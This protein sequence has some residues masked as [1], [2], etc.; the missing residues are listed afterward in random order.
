MSA[1]R[2]FAASHASAVLAGSGAMIGL[3]FGAIVQRT[4]FCAMGA[5]SDWHAFGD[6][7]R[8][9]AWVLSAT[10]ALLATQSLAAAGVVAVDKSMY[11]APSLNW[12]GN[13]A[14]GLLFGF[15][16][17]LAGGCASRNIVRAG[18]GDLR[19]LLNLVI[20]G[21]TSYVA[22]GGLLGPLRAALE[23]TTAV[24]LTR[25]GAADQS[26]ANLL[27]RTGFAAPATSAFVTAI[28]VAVPA[29]VWC[30]ASPPFR[31]SPLHVASAC[32][33]AACVIAGWAATGL[34]YDELAIRPLPPVSLTYVRPTGDTLEWLQRFTALGA[35]GFGV[36]SVFGGALGGFAVAA[37]TG[38]LTSRK[39]AEARTR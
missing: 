23:S 35:P 20:I 14:G 29:C 27:Q 26:L 6:T 19:A 34:A 32:G 25:Y 15:G 16:M 28:L 5:V 1:L 31:R 24:D 21:I 3:L 13:I 37:V 7:R 10:L 18:T 38:R 33:I 39:G 30:F 36:A 9:R 17:V 22:I 12:M 11:L 8:L 4:G 2:D